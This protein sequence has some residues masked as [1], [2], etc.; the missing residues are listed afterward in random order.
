M[1]TFIGSR[2]PRSSLG[3]FDS[4][5]VMLGSKLP[6]KIEKGARQFQ[7]ESPLVSWL[8]TK[9]LNARCF[10]WS[11]TLQLF[12]NDFSL[13][14]ALSV[15]RGN[16]DNL[17]ST[18]TSK[19]L[20][21]V[22]QVILLPLN[23]SFGGNSLFCVVDFKSSLGESQRWSYNIITTCEMTP[24]ELLSNAISHSLKPSSKVILLN[25]QM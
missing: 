2:E 13:E 24:S 12:K 21:D 8:L 25:L 9:S 3:V 4:L 6:S 10:D 20:T 5:N 14:Y 18:N 11:D 16:L 1:R 22:F 15:W 7:L 17:L 23:R 19:Y